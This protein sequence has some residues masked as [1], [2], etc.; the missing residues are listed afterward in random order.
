MK[1]LNKMPKGTILKARG[2]QKKIEQSKP[3][4]SRRKKKRAQINVEK[5]K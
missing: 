2:K 5:I 1:G 4:V 3:K